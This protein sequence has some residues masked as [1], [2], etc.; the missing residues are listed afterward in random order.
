MSEPQVNARIKHKQCSYFHSTD[1]KKKT[2]GGKVTFLKAEREN[3]SGVDLFH[4]V[5]CLLI[6]TFTSLLNNQP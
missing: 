6:N 3:W 5:H 2:Q 4:P 1:G